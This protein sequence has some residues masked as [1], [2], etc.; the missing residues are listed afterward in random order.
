MSPIDVSD[1]ESG[2]LKGKAEYDEWFAQ[3]IATWTR[4]IQ[5]L[6]I[7]SMAKNMPLDVRLSNPEDAATI[8]ELF[9]E[10]SGHG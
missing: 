2:Y 1:A 10:M 7:A 9:E 3:F 6:A 8:M 4:P 5:M